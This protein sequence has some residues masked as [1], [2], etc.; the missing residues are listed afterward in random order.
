MTRCSWSQPVGQWNP[1]DSARW[2]CK[3]QYDYYYYT[4][5][6]RWRYSYSCAPTPGIS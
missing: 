4:I 1:R 6:C 5:T 3:P 2:R